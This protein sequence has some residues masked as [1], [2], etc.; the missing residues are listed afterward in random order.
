MTLRDLL[1]VLD[2]PGLRAPGAGGAETPAG[3]VPVLDVVCDSRAVSPGAVFV[4]LRG[5]R[6]DGAA[7]AA[8]AAST[9]AC[10]VVSE[11]DAPPQFP[12]PWVRVT[13][14]RLALAL[15]AASVHGHPSR[16]M[17]VVGITG[18][19]GKTTTSFLAQ[20]VFEAAGIRCGLLGTVHYR[21]GAEAQDAVRTTPEAPELQ[22]LL[23]EMAGAG[24]GAC[25]ME[26]SSHA[27]A[28]K[29]ADGTEFAA[30]AFTNLTRDHLDFHG[31]MDRYFAAKRRLFD[32]LPDGAPSI[33]N[34]DDRRGASL[35][36]SRRPCVTF[37]VDAP[38]DVRPAAMPASLAALDFS[39]AAR[40]VTLRISSPLAGRFNLSNLLAAAAIGVA[41]DL[42]AQ[43]IEAGLSS[44]ASVPGRFQVVSSA[45]DDVTV[46]VD[47][48][49]TDDALRNVLEAVRAM[50]GARLTTVFGCGGDRDRAKRP[51][52][53]DVAA[54]LS[55]LVVV[56]SDNPRSEDPERILDDIERGIPP[57]RPRL[58]LADRRVAIG[59]AIEGAGAG[60]V[61]VVAGKGHEK[62]QVIGDRALPFDD[63]AVA[64]DA[65]DRRRL[66]ST[67]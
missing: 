37:A 63:A 11:A 62:K 18:T 55:D 33:V 44:V 61:V 22:R 10:A 17:R 30:A 23:R 27:L 47:Y 6:V 32:L 48:A 14:A 8:Q 1:I 43:A 59:R 41:L 40:G 58:R 65:L 25:V 35:A 4:A 46:I 36:A 64:R 57:H 45:A 54:R 21:V 38:A 12:V 13:D 53:G 51:L 34:V 42:P 5:Q 67:P 49:H 9:G 19:N 26:V 60:D 20:A 66:R 52:M 16:S 3:G 7:F 50:A 24:C 2:G 28:L 31:D 39:V 15:L 56:T 29:R